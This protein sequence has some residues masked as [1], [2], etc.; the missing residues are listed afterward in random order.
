MTLTA[1]Q[2]LDQLRALTLKERL[3]VVERT[4]HGL[5]AEMTPAPPAALAA[6]L[7]GDE[8]DS[9]FEAF[10]SAVQR[11]RSNDV[12]RTGNAEDALP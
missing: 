2:V 4:I 3:Y 12:C 8:S 7:W 9:D 6:S 5:P 11:L 10:Q 1:E